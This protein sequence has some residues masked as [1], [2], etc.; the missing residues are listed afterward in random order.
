LMKKTVF[1]GQFVKEFEENDPIESTN[2]VLD[3]GS[4]WMIFV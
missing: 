1:R 4:I 2:S 3:N